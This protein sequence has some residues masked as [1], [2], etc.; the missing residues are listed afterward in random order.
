MWADTLFVKTKFHW[1][2]RH[3][4][5]YENT[6]TKLLEIFYSKKSTI[7]FGIQVAA[8]QFNRFNVT[9]LANTA[10]S[11]SNKQMLNVNFLELN[12]SRLINFNAEFTRRR[13]QLEICC[14]YII[15]CMICLAYKQE[16]VILYNF[17]G[18]FGD[19]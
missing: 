15:Q 16:A 1:K 6:C 7:Q 17:K 19:R 14:R 2:N 5:L 13:S 4:N 3:L 11:C 12:A 9:S 8:C 10:V 18:S